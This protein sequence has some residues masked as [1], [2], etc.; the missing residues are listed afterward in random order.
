MNGE[1]RRRSSIGY[2]LVI[3]F[4][5]LVLALS[6]LLNAGLAAGLLFKSAHRAG[7]R[8]RGE[9]EYPS[10]TERHS[11]GRGAVKVVRIPVTGVITRQ[12]DGGLFGTP[13]DMTESVLRQVRAAT[14]D[15]DVGGLLVEVDSPGGAITPTDEIYEALLAFRESRDDRRVVVFVRDMA[16]SGGYYVAMAGDHVVAEPTA[17][18][19]SISVLVQALNWHTLSEKIGISDTTIKSGRNKDLLNPFREVNPEH[20]AVLQGV[21][22]EMHEQF[23]AIVAASRELGEDDAKRLTDGSVFTANRAFEEGLVDEVGYWEDAMDAI[24]ELLGRD[25]VRIVRY[26][27]PQ[28][29]VD[30]FAQLRNPL[31]APTALF[32]PQPARLMYLWRP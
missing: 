2:W 8:G 5:G 7:P 16:A 13:F 26:E 1:T 4:L 28:R 23:V 14:H 11:Y 22:D 25:E 24:G 21:V 10:F 31:A 3:L 18:V 15:D 32:R 6:V 20:V 29:L 9:D 12:V 19:G 30:L 17:L 27:R